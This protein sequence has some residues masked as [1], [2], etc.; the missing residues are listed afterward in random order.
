MGVSGL[1]QVL[2]EQGA[3]TTLGINQPGGHAA[4]ARLV[5]G[6][7]VA[8][9]LSQWLYQATSQPALAGLYEVPEA[10]CL[11]VVFDRVRP[12]ALLVWETD[13]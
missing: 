10:R 2:E 6:Q 13:N 4:V 12:G 5:D 7:A 9:D 11:K 8:V 1:W 3:V